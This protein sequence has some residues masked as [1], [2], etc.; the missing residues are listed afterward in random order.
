M[1]TFFGLLIA[2]NIIIC[3]PFLTFRLMLST[4]V[5]CLS[6]YGSIFVATFSAV[7]HSIYPTLVYTFCQ[8]PHSFAP[9][10]NHL[11]IVFHL[12]HSTTHS[13]SLARDTILPYTLSLLLS[14]CQYQNYYSILQSASL[15]F[16]LST[17]SLSFLSSY[18]P[19]ILPLPLRCVAPRQVGTT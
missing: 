2:L 6:L 14:I 13:F 7:V 4:S 11:R 19:I 8:L 9:C 10:D 16:F 5:Y 1:S 15:P 17:N 3:L 18:T 12:H